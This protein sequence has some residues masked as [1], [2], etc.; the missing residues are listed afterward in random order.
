M[1]THAIDQNAAHRF[2]ARSSAVILAAGLLLSALGAGV[3]RGEADCNPGEYLTDAQGNPLCWPD[4][5]VPVCFNELLDPLLDV[6]NGPMLR[7]LAFQQAVA[8]WNAALTAV[9]SGITLNAVKNPACWAVEQTLNDCTDPDKNGHAVYDYGWINDNNNDAST[10]KPTMDLTGWIKDP[11]EGIIQYS[12]IPDNLAQEVLARCRVQGAN[13]V[14]TRA[15]IGWMTEVETIVACPTI[16]WNFDHM[17]A[18]GG[19]AGEF[20]FYSVMLHELGHL[21]GL[22]HLDPGETGVMQSS[23]DK[24]TRLGI[25]DEEKECLKKC[26][27]VP[28]PVRRATW[29]KVK[30]LY[31]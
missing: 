31:Q 30:S 11:G 22:G 8:D 13:G 7:W 4:G 15:D 28:L 21:L 29:G 23:I 16:P 1:S 9:G 5:M 27:S 14:I 19:F 17:L 6:P 25:T 3:A 2:V 12:Q 24:N 10:G 26:V 20:D 18:A